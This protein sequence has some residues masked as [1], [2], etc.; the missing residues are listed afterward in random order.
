MVGA[1]HLAVT[2]CAIHADDESIA[3]RIGIFVIKKQAEMSLATATATT[4]TT[5][6]TA[7]KYRRMALLA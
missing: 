4:T 3:S 5:T 6:T 2:I 7:R 1:M